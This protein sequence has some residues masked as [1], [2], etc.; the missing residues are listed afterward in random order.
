M[1]LYIYIQDVPLKNIKL[2]SNYDD[3]HD[4]REFIKYV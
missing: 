4:V 1:M 3:V 2:M